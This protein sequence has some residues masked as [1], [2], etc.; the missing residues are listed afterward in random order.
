[1]S[2]IN[3]LQSGC[4]FVQYQTPISAGGTTFSSNFEKGG[5]E[6]KKSAWE[7]SK[8]PYHRYMAG[9]L[10]FF[11]KKGFVKWIMVLRAK[12]SNDNLGLF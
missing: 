4:G 9:A 6:K 1:M 2:E 8:S 3:K 10:M 5:S 11:V 7:V 12:F